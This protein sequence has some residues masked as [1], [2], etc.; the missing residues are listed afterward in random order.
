V[1]RERGKVVVEQTIEQLAS[2][3]AAR[4]R[5]GTAATD[6]TG[7][8]FTPRACAA[9]ADRRRTAH[10]TFAARTDGT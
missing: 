6:G 8:G 4:C 3:F 2:A 1:R 9:R 5:A 10:V 7:R